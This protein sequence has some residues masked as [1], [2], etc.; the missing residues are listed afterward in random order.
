MKQQVPAE[1]ERR[2]LDYKRLAAYLGISLRGA[3]QLAAEGQI[4]KVQIGHRVLFDR[5]DVDAYIERIK[6]AS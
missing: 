2:L 1:P 4:L 5:D 6:K 3:K